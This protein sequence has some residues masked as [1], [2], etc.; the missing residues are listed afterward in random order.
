MNYLILYSE[1]DND[2]HD[3]FLRFIFLETFKID[4]IIIIFE[5]ITYK[6]HVF[7]NPYNK[8]N[9]RNII[10]EKDIKQR[11]INKVEEIKK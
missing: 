3:N 4:I 11:K 6:L 10:I 1:I 5:I 8:I 2:L 7:S 9:V